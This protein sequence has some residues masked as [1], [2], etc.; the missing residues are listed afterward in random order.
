[1]AVIVCSISLVRGFHGQT[2]MGR[3][4]GGDFVQ[5]YVAGKILNEH[6]TQKLYD[7]DLEV[8]LQHKAVPE[9][10]KDQML[11]FA[12]APYVAQ[13]YR[14]FALLPYTWAYVAWLAI[15]FGLY[16]AGVVLLLRSAGLSG[17]I[18]NTALLL[19]ISSMPFLMETWIGGQISV[20]AFVA[21]AGFAFLRSRNQPFVAGLILSLAFFKPTLIAIPVLMLA[22][23]R[24]WKMLAGVMAGSV[25]LGLLSLE[26]VGL[27]GCR[28]WVDT[29]TFYGRLATGSASALHRSKYVDLGS[30]FHLALGN[31][32]LVAEILS[33]VLF[34]AGLALLARTWWRSANWPS[35]SRD[36]LW[37]ATIAG[38]LVLNVYSPIYDTILLTIGVGMGA[39]AVLETTGRD[40]EVFQGWMV[41]LYIVPW[42]T[43]SFAEFL[44]F[45]PFTLV[46][47]GFACWALRLAE[48]TASSGSV[49]KTATSVID[50]ASAV[51]AEEHSTYYQSLGLAPYLVTGS[52]GNSGGCLSV[53]LRGYWCRTAFNMGTR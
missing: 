52:T 35:H 16:I 51:S 12:S 28:R 46:L 33:V 10:A 15:S 14:P 25:G 3:A 21:L 29:L 2:F 48:R 41:L 39:K 40:R 36:L 6:P 9:A 30:F 31:S 20:L 27:D 5:F 47:A 17:V 7:L 45:Q 11:V 19:A 43:Q 24:R 22:F 1:M 8:D 32:S 44:R 42:I 13:I 38:A 18:G 50:H 34:V 49:G 4:L 26:T 53:L 23:G 37:M